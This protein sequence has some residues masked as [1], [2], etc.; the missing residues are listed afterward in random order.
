MRDKITKAIDALA[1]AA[2]IEG[3]VS[4]EKTQTARDLTEQRKRELVEAISSPCLHQISEPSVNQQLTA[5]PV[6]AMTNALREAEA[7]LEVALARILKADP[8]H[9]I[10]VTSEAKALVAVRQALSSQAAPVAVM[11][12][13]AFEDA[14]ALLKKY[15]KLCVEV[16][17]GDSFHLARIDKARAALAATPADHSEQDLK[18]AE[19]AP[20]V[21][22]EPKVNATTAVELALAHG[23]RRVSAYGKRGDPVLLYP[24]DLARLLAGVSAPA[25]QADRLADVVQQ[26]FDALQN[27]ID[28]RGPIS[29]GNLQHYVNLL[30]EAFDAS[31]PAPQQADARDAAPA[32]RSEIYDAGMRLIGSV[33]CVLGNPH[34]GAQRDAMSRNAANLH[35]ALVAAP[36][37]NT[38]AASEQD[39][40]KF[41]AVIA[42]CG[43]GVFFRN[44]ADARW[45]LTGHGSGSDGFGVPTIGEAFRESYEDYELELVRVHI[46]AQSTQQGGAA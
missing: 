39:A 43:E 19:A 12:R 6:A 25:A 21:L 34:S 10:S 20:V 37:P 8:G 17:R 23:G 7:A 36:Q 46:A 32:A 38:P 11:E 14:A 29:K 1:S 16:G 33:Q 35:S 3:G 45:T 42:P 18:M 41:W 30:R 44:E 15:R 5:A 40:R 13:E 27:K 24:D 22:P 31:E 9:S 2:F 28:A 26:V 4:A